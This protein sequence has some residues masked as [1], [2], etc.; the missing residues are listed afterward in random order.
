MNQKKENMLNLALTLDE[1]ERAKTYNL[2]TGYDSR[3]D[4]WELIV[5]YTGDI[6]EQVNLLNGT[7][8]ELSGGYAIVNI[9]QVNIDRLTDLPEV[10]YIE[11]S[12][13]LIY[14]MDYP[15]IASCIPQVHNSPLSLSGRGV[16]VA[17]IDSGIDYLHP[18]FLNS[19]GTTRI[20]GINN[21]ESGR[22]YDS[23][24][25]NNAIQRRD[26]SLAGDVSGHGT[27]VAGIAAGNKGVAF[28][29]DILVVKLGR[30]NFFTTARMME[31]LDYCVKTAI[32][33]GEPIAVNISFGNNYGSHD[34]TSLVET[35]MNYIADTWQNVIVV[36][37]GNEADLRIHASGT[38]TGENIIRELVIG[39]FETSLDFSLWK[40]Y[41]DDFRITVMS[42]DGRTA[43]PVYIENSVSFYNFGKVYLY[44]YFG[45]PSPYSVNQEIFFQL[46][47][48]EDYLTEGLWRIMLEPVDITDGRYDIWLSTGSTVST[49]TGF[50]V[51]EAETTLTTPSTSYKVITVGAYDAATGR[52]AD[53]SG[54][55]YTRNVK[56][57]KPDIVAPGVNI[58]SSAVGGGYVA[59]TGTSMATPF[60]TGS[61]ALMMQWGI[62]EKN[63]IFLYGEKI[64][65]NLIR[66]AKVLPSFGKVP[67]ERVGW[68]ALCLADSIF[69]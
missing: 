1:S 24:E 19:D 68:G 53:F 33:R 64:K 49:D 28:E 46:I 62:V 23:G 18:D 63:D 47:A 7:I 36:G 25:I 67:N 4:S 6:R 59:K 11:K 51:T 27:H 30:D 32:G 15:E 34:G 20:I 13:K 58:V 56:T 3:T 45:E 57:V 65:A 31:A 41:R 22:I 37:A 40:N 55:G 10:F 61:A 9:P 44:V 29:S 2:N 52:Y 16:I 43:G 54:R 21:Q 60:V 12:K 17:V 39:R 48:T 66:G 5:R 26:R 14:A 35:Y 50:T 69:Q 8:N 42:P 38:L